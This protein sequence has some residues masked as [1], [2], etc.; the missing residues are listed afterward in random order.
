MSKD[1]SFLV[2]LV[3]LLDSGVALALFRN[4]VM[5]DLIQGDMAPLTD[6][7]VRI[8]LTDKSSLQ[9]GLDAVEIHFSLS[10]IDH[11]VISRIESFISLL[12]HLSE[13]PSE[14]W[15]D[16]QDGHDRFTAIAYAIAWCPLVVH[17]AFGEH[18]FMRYAKAAPLTLELGSEVIH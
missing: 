9:R 3:S 11:P 4:S 12:Q 15:N 6:E 17:R 5:N 7:Y 8:S 10:G 2:P 14:E 1:D 16:F 18:V 13:K